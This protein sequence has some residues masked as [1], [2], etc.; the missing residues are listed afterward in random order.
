MDGGKSGLSQ[1]TSSSKPHYETVP[2]TALKNSNIMSFKNTFQH[3]LTQSHT[4]CSILFTYL[5]TTPLAIKLIR[6]A[7]QCDKPQEKERTFSFSKRLV[8]ENEPERI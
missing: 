7:L 5:Y 3:H 4:F 1:I 6:G 2:D 8:E